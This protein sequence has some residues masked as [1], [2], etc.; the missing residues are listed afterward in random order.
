MASWLSQ[1]V[2]RVRGLF[3]QK[4]ADSEF[5]I[6]MRMHLQLLAEQFARQ[7]MRREDAVSAA[8]RQFGNTA[9]LKQ[10]QRETRT[11]LSVA[12]VL[13]DGRYGLRM[14]ARSPGFTAIAVG[15][16]ALG[17]GA[18]TAI[19]NLAKHA[20]LDRLDVPHAEEL[21][22]LWWSQPSN[23][24]VHS[25]WGYFNG[26]L[27][28]NENSTSFSYPVYKQLQ[29][30]N[31]SLESLF[32]FKPFRRMTA[33]ID[34]RAAAVTAE[35]VSG[36]YYPSLGVRPVL[37]RAISEA[38]DAVP[39]SGQVIVISDEFWARQFDRS[40]HVLGKVIDINLTPMTIIGVNPP[41]FSGADTTHS[42]PDIFLPLSM[43][44]VV[45]PKG[46]HSLLTDTDLWWV[47]IM[48]REKPGVS[49]AAAAAALN[50]ALSA[51]VRATMPIE[52]G[53]ELPRLELREGS[54][55][56]NED[57][58]WMSKPIYVLLALS[59]FV[60]LLA[61]ANLANLLLARS[62]TR[63]R[64]MSVRLAIGAGRARIL[65][66]MLTESLLLALIGGAAG[67]LLAYLV[68]DMIPRLLSHPWGPVHY[69]GRIDWTILG[70]TAA[71]SILTALI[72][73]VA[74]A[75]QSA[76][77]N[78][79]SG[80]KD[81]AQT[82]THR[83][84]GIAGNALVVVQVSLSMLLLVVAG[85]FVRT[86]INLGDTHLGFRPDHL[87]LFDIEPPA[88]RYTAAKD[89]A[90]IGQLEEK[91]SA[92]PGVDSVTHSQNALIAGNVIHSKF[93]PS[94]HREQPVKN[95]GADFN[96]VGEHFFSTMGIPLIA[97]RGFSNGDTAASA[98][99]AVIDSQLANEFFPNV[100]PLGRTFTTDL[101]DK[102]SITIVGICGDVKYARV[103]HAFR[104]TYYLLYRQRVDLDPR[105]TFEISTRMKREAMVSS[106]RAAVQS[107]DNNLPLLDIR[108]QAEQ[109]EATMQQQRL[110][111]ELT[112]GF[113][114]LALALA[115]IGIY[116]MM[117]YTVSRRTNEIGIRMA[118]GA[119]SE[120]VLRMVI[121]EALWITVAGVT[122]GLGSALV[123]G[124]YI[125]SLLFDLKSWDPAT[126]VMTTVILMAAAL[127]ASWF[128]ARRAAAIDP[129]QALRHE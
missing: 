60:L 103:S 86:L 36:N 11:F 91:L 114:V 6:E 115:C 106:L 100:N 52:K 21:R 70:F 95:G 1:L 54:R 129:M 127:G 125:S 119:P 42:S 67:L 27:G 43:Q 120:Q 35:M 58:D 94:E 88:N 31:R 66:Q 4:K 113:G 117:A 50:V 75:W 62:T 102:S 47:V 56:Q 64:E 46:P 126:L 73:G 93:L 107:V 90:L 104:P 10:R 85:L 68:R 89:I 13:Q 123:L 18:N 20:L 105:A 16:L 22:M 124:Q 109:I 76:R 55:G 19:F 110:C 57:A 44:P 116:G 24:V 15:S 111:A 92:V 74:P 61:C 112:A 96:I 34:G 5:E 32:A 118:L 87:L 2:S 84:K 12:T 121:F 45:G 8:R 29:K 51:A 80:L 33:T 28:G 39:G 41:G 108:T 98:K 59:G 99:V 9:L 53:A 3:G 101:P 23:G 69:S 77:T 72:F 37:G 7:G 30:E 38:D 48:G 79:S 26:T 49:D 65:R 122:A 81:T 17:I 63:Q 40:P 78:V 71:I 128:P 82:I 97:G 14:L 83:R 25:F